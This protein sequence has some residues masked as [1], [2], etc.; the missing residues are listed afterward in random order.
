[1]PLRRYAFSELKESISLYRLKR[2]TVTGLLCVH[3]LLNVAAFLQCLIKDLK[4]QQRGRFVT[5]NFP[6]LIWPEQWSLTIVSPNESAN[7]PAMWYNANLPKW[8]TRLFHLLQISHSTMHH[9]VP[10][11]GVQFRKQPRQC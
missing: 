10:N 2:K 4:R 6:R 11:A 1:L 3:C 7:S 5:Y 8:A 9:H